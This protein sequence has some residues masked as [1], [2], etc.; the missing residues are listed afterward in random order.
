MQEPVRCDM[1][2]GDTARV[3]VRGT[4]GSGL[5]RRILIAIVRAVM[6]AM[7]AVV[8]VDLD[9]VTSLDAAAA[10][11]L[12]QAE[13]V[14]RRVGVHM[15]IVAADPA[16]RRELRAAGLNDLRPRFAAEA[17]LPPA[18]PA[19]AA[20][21]LATPFDGDSIARVRQRIRDCTAVHLADVYHQYRFVLA[22][23]EMMSNAVCH[24]GGHGRLRLWY[25]GDAL[26]AE[27]SD[28]GPGI[29]AQPG[30]GGGRPGPGAGRGLWL[31]REVCAELHVSSGR[32]G[33][34]VL[35]RYVVPLPGAA[36]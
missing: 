13:R 3:V 7:V 5:A 11:A 1:V 6:H 34:I 30:D 16:I 25:T 19:A 12:A 9:G 36:S 29:A 18:V 22:V 2:A 26:L 35:L 31:A 24:G 4:V 21:L 32:L 14:A 20:E 23:S 17:D 15:D 28:H 27:I 10:E 33:T 8:F